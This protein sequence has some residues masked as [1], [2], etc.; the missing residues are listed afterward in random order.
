MG[1]GTKGPRSILKDLWSTTSTYLVRVGICAGIVAIILAGVLSGRDA[2]VSETQVI[3]ILTGVYQAQEA[4]SDVPLPVTLLVRL[5]TTQE[6]VQATLS[7]PTPFR[8]GQRVLLTEG[9]TK[10]GQRRYRFERYLDPEEERKLLRDRW[11]Q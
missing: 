10:F 6:R 1:R 11:P 9:S 2:V 3:G 7:G 8:P 4:D 5:D